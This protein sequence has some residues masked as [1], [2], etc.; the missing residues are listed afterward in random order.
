MTYFTQLLTEKTHT[1]RLPRRS[2]DDIQRLVRAKQ[3]TSVERSPF[4]RQLDFWAFSIATSLAE[5]LQPI[6]G[7]SNKWGD[8]FVD[9][10]AVDM[11]A[12]L[13]NILAVAAFHHLGSE[14][15]GIDDPAQIV[16]VGN[17]LAGAGCPVVLE[18]LNSRD[19]RLNPIDHVLNFAGHLYNHVQ[20]ACI[21]RR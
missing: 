7:P 13:C 21:S 19:L 12:A 8:K 3:A 6:E 16:E 11:S 15:D 17:C 4:R 2:T 1:L 9:T 18:Q 20:V 10:R 5:G 14:H